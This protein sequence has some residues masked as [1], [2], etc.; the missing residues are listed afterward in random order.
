MRLID[1]LELAPLA[2]LRGVLADIDETISTQ[3]KLSPQAYQALW[4]LHDSG[5]LVIPVTGRSAGWCDHIARFWPVHAVVGENGGFYFHHDGTSVRRRYLDEAEQRAA[6]RER[7]AGIGRRILSEV[8][9]SAIASDQQYRE[10]DLAIDFCE[11][12]PPLERGEV[13]RI[14]EI[15]QEEGAHAK[16]SSIHVNGWFG[17]FDK[18]STTR[19]CVS[20]LFGVDLEQENTSFVF[21][22]DSPNDE[23]MF[24]FFDLSV[25]MANI[26]PFLHLIRQRPTFVTRRPSGDGFVEVAEHILR[27]GRSSPQ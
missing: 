9:G 3:G 15:F 20:E 18:L 27:A 2:G 21:C 8:P 22:G 6:Y 7:L 5:L 16:I 12:V 14:Q 11:D 1:E 26:E 10:Y 4:D 19:L 23:P 24:G 17:D 13:V 25:A